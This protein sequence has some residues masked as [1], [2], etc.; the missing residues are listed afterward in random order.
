MPEIRL[1]FPPDSPTL[2][3]QGPNEL[4]IQW[5][6]SS[7]EDGSA[8]KMTSVSGYQVQIAQLPSKSWR[9]VGH[10][11]TSMDSSNDDVDGRKVGA[12]KRKVRVARLKPGSGYVTRVR[13]QNR[14]GWG[15]WSSDSTE[16]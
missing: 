9:D 5:D 8:G 3:R 16:M 14:Y 6:V 10:L 7:A 2:V 4:V 1:P 12:S 11:R 15:G 13:A